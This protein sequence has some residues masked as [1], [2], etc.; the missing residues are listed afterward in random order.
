MQR[1]C[2]YTGPSSG[3]RSRKN[4]GSRTILMCG[5]DL[6]TTLPNESLPGEPAGAI[7]GTLQAW[8]R[9]PRRLLTTGERCDNS[10]S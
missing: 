5:C 10:S 4:D 7:L 1:R 2:R 9:V 3:S 6:N 8:M